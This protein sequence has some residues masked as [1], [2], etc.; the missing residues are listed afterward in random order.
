MNFEPFE[1]QILA[2]FKQNVIDILGRSQDSGSLEEYEA[3]AKMTM[4][5]LGV[6]VFNLDQL[7]FLKDW[8]DQI[9]SLKFLEPILKHDD[10][11]EI[12]LHSHQYY[13]LH[14]NNNWDKCA[15][16][17]NLEDYRI[18][19]ERLAYHYHQEWNYSHP[20]TSFQISLFEC[21]LRCTLVHSSCHASGQH[22]VFLRKQSQ[23][24]YSAESYFED[25]NILCKVKDWVQSKKNILIAGAT[26]SGKTSFLSTI[27]Q[28]IPENEHLVIMED[29]KELNFNHQ[30]ISALLADD[31]QS[32]RSLKD[33]CTYSLRMRPDRIILGEVRGEEIVPLI[34]NLN[35]GHKGMMCTLHANTALET[36]DRLSLLF[37][38]YSDTNQL[39]LKNIKQLICTNVDFIIFIR[40]RQ[41]DQI[42]KILGCEEGRPYFE[43]EYQK[44]II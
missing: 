5:Q 27:S 7:T 12:I 31:L 10:L 1:T 15:L 3:L 44:N 29:T 18:A 13:Y 6:E 36:L 42:I 41:V 9:I 43:Y 16:N 4:T 37:S 8:F 40:E 28:Y 24:N 33:F 2:Q 14:Y 30:H 19:W 38:L 23:E 25:K 21:N 39:S 35:N 22:Q 17:L 32:G 11:Q 26:G 20:F 34:L